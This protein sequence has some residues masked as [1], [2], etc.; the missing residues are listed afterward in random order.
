MNEAS[1]ATFFGGNAH[2]YTDYPDLE[3]LAA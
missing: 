2:G 3:A 1:P